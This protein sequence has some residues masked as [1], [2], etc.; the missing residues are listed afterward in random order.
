MAPKDKKTGAI[1]IDKLTD[2]QKKALFEKLGLEV[3]KKTKNGA[4][5]WRCDML[6]S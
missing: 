3:N 6:A 4:F 1:D 2:K 5:F